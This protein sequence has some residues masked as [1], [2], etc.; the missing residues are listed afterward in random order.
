M[1]ERAAR[2]AGADEVEPHGAVR[3]FDDWTSERPPAMHRDLRAGR[4]EDGDEV[5]LDVRLDA[6]G[7][8]Q[9]QELPGDGPARS[10]PP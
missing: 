5:S 7:R 6:G 1:T 4:P 10:H 3:E 2:P 8:P 9:S